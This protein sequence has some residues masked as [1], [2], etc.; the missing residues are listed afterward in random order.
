MEVEAVIPRADGTVSV[1]EPKFEHRTAS[2]LGVSH[3]FAAV[4]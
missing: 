1:L 4:S 3:A 2:V